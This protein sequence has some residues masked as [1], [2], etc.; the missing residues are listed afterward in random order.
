VA[1]AEIMDRFLTNDDMYLK[2]VI[3]EANDRDHQTIRSSMD[4]DLTMRRDTGAVTCCFDLLLIAAEIPHDILKILGITHIEKLGHDLI[5]V[6]N[7]RAPWP[8]DLEGG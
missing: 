7:V 4:A 5:C 3:D 6:G 2:A 1:S 8:Y